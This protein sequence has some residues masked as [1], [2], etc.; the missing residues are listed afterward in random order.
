M[1]RIGIDLGGTKI[2]AGL[3]D[4]NR[5]LGPAVQ[6]PTGL[7]KPAKELAE[8]IYRLTERLLK[9]QGLTFQD[10]ESVGIGIPGTVNKETDCIEYANN[11]GFEN[12][13]FLKML[14]DLFPCPVYGE[15][16]PRLL[17]G[18]NIWQVQDGAAVP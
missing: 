4:E 5:V 6:E 2:A 3:V 10:V 16:M 1:L 7:P 15:M 12:V 14:K 17:P 11:F 9:E 8:A 18:A 13:P